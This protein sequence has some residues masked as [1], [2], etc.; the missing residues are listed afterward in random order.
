MVQDSQLG[1]AVV[2][3]SRNGQTPEES[4]DWPASM[5]LCFAWKSDTRIIQD[6]AK[7]HSMAPLLVE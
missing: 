5:L 4:V 2:T 1:F 6:C 7:R 3:W